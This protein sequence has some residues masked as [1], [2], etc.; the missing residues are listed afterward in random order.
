MTLNLFETQA[1]A[2]YSTANTVIYWGGHSIGK[3]YMG[4]RWCLLRLV[5]WRDSCGMA[6]ADTYPAQR[7]TMAPN[8]EAFIDLLEE[9][10]LAPGGITW[11]Q[12]LGE[13]RCRAMNSVLFLRSADKPKSV[14]GSSLSHAWGDEVTLWKEDAY[15]R[16]ALR[17]RE[18]G[19]GEPF[20]LPHR[21]HPEGVTFPETQFLN[22][23]T[24]RR[25]G[26]AWRSLT[27]DLPGRERIYAHAMQN[28]HNS[29][30]LYDRIGSLY[31]VG[32]PKWRQ[33]VE[34]APLEPEGLCYPYFN[35]AMI[36]EPPVNTPWRGHAFGVDWGWKNPKVL[37]VVSMD[38]SGRCY[39]RD[40]WVESE[41]PIEDMVVEAK[42]LRGIYGA[43]IMFCDPS[44]PEDIVRMQREGFNALPANNAVRPG[45]DLVNGRYRNGTLFISPRCMK[46]LEEV[47]SYGFRVGADG[48]ANKDQ[49][50]DADD[51]CMD[52]KRYCLAGMDGLGLELPEQEHI[53]MADVVPGWQEFAGGAAR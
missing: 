28:P 46:T 48:T 15:D 18:K 9:S 26:W 1:K 19:P 6:V 10:G 31:G 27:K 39:I 16:L 29:R 43:S 7:Q 44:S 41:T 51:H 45:I 24:F 49:P 38:A 13:I 3:T 23:F 8:L 37:L 4:A 12:T 40:E 25:K 30:T 17:C 22:T 34:G 50:V 52:A 53:T 2:F 20:W 32:S 33:A 35:E 42:R 21:D 11:N 47:Q 14:E 5:S 36:Q